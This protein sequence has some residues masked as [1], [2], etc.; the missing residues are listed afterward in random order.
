MLYN[1]FKRG[2]REAANKHVC[3]CS[4]N[5][6]HIAVLRAEQ[7]MALSNRP[8]APSYMATLPVYRQIQV[9]S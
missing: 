7:T 4:I 3:V 5:R 2:G 9:H 1:E 6:S 8:I